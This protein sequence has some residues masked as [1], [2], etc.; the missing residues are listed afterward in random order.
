MMIL[1][2]I[3]QNK[4]LIGLITVSIT[5]IFVF[6]KW[7]DNRN[8]ELKEKRYKTYMDLIGV[9]SGKRADSS[10]PNISEQIAAVW[11]LSE[12][13]EYYE[14]TKKIFSESDFENMSDKAWVQHILPHIHKLL[15]EI[16]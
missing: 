4:D 5:G 6:I 16:S 2:F 15:K 9:I 3:T 14:I 7:I 1:Q 11:F 12:Y 10:T 13:K 8:R